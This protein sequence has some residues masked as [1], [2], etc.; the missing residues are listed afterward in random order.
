[1]GSKQKGHKGCV[2]CQVTAVEQKLSPAD[3]AVMNHRV[4]KGELSQR[5]KVQKG[6]IGQKGAHTKKPKGDIHVAR[7]GKP[8]VKASSTKGKAG[9]KRRAARPTRVTAKY[10]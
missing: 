9:P 8:T 3:Q 1:M 4:G 6:Y 10:K 7:S 5:R 2:F